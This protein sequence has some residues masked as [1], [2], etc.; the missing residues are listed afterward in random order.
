[1]VKFIINR[2][3]AVLMT[4][5]AFL[6][7]GM[8][9]SSR[10]PTALLPD[11]AIPEITVQLTYP[12]NTAR[13]METNVVRVLRNQLLQ[14]PNLKDI[15]SETRDGWAT[16]RLTFDYGTNTDFAFIEANEKIDAALNF[17]PRDLERPKVIK[18]SASD[19]P[20]LNMA[21][22][23]SD[24]YSDERFLELSDFTE[25]VLKKR[26]EQLPDV[27]L[28]DMSGLA[29]PE[30]VVIPNLKK[31]QSLGITNED[32]ATA[33]QQNNFVLGNLLIQN[34]IYQYNF[35]FANP[36]QTTE[37]IDNIFVT[38]NNRLF[39]LKELAQV[40]L[41]PET[42]R[43]LAY[44]NGK[45]AIVLAV[46]K[47]S[48]A[49]VYHLKESLSNLALSFKN[50]YKNIVFHILQDQSQLLK[51]SIDNLKQSLLLGSFLAIIIM[52]F[53]LK[54]LQSPLLIAFSIPVSLVMSLLFMYLFGLSI[55]IIS[56]S[57][58]ILG[59]G[60]MIDNSIIVI[61]NINQKLESGYN[62]IDACGEGTEE[63]ITPLLSSVL[64]TVSVFFPLVFLSGISGALFY[65]QALAVAIGLFASLIV[66]ILL[67]PVLFKLIKNKMFF[68]IKW[69]RPQN[70]N[71]AIEDWY[72]SGYRLF[73]KKKGLLFLIVG[74]FLAIGIILFLKMP[75]GKLPEFKQ[76]ESMLTLDWNENINVRENQKRVDDLLKNIGQ[77]EVYLSQTGEQQYLLN[78]E[79]S[80]SFSEAEVYV[81]TDTPE[82]LQILLAHLTNQL[83]KYPQAVF[84]FNPP[85]NILEYIFGNDKNQLT[86]KVFSKTNREVPPENSL[87]EIESVL[88]FPVQD[89]IPVEKTAYIEVIHENV[90]LYDIDYN[91]LMGELK[92]AFNQ[93]MVDNLKTA[94][95][96][97][98]IKIYY[99]QDEV[100]QIL[101]K[102]FV[103][104]KAD[105]L[106]PMRSLVR[107]YNA[108]KYKSIF[109]DRNGEYLGINLIADKNENAIIQSTADKIRATSD[110]NVRF[111]G[112]YFDLKA[113]TSELSTVILVSL[114]LL[115]FIMAAQ[116]ESLWQPLIILLEIPI[117][118]GGALLLLWLF[119][120]T[121]NI[122]AA[123]GIVVMSGVVIN[124][125]ILK[126][127]TINIFLK[128]GFPMDVS[129]KKA[130]KL[131]FKPIL[132]TSLTTILALGPFLFISGLG[133][134]LQKP[135]ALTV[136]GGMTIGTFVSLYFVPL[137]F[138]WFYKIFHKDSSSE[139]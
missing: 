124:D 49:Q 108:Q 72:E 113:L 139:K 24:N 17:L 128:D 41:R 40:V 38:V 25:T 60:M 45:R 110:F 18:A 7:L 3:I 83:K 88:G 123:I 10:L 32:I 31:I 63:L 16:I 56:L 112:N 131:R 1:M 74:C 23:L 69:L 70:K 93:N 75:Y 105:Q 54:D 114:F 79:N 134:E 82:N 86:A 64:T 13:E 66:S 87:P 15:E 95:K 103:K 35:K 136:I 36:L 22:T 89:L 28:A 52:F 67:I 20:I 65:D 39:R 6:L 55:N 120:G 133:A 125:S 58:L 5:L 68:Q 109:A 61:D 44:Y 132:M 53:F 21:V 118:L 34:G 51:L 37:D 84:Q 9:T 135:L 91:Q 85:K 73:F 137:M 42:E 106:I 76:T 81:K 107:I 14:I 4:T 48:D 90:L 19:I 98:P 96:F 27:A 129:I 11:I 111:S 121:I 92:S 62:L 122:M 138:S 97:I 77:V 100:E 29:R 26:I 101:N 126:I 57:G 33:I 115:Y 117:D 119:G 71:L 46:I 8:A 47:Q 2:P 30:I 12:N 102:L 94:Q 59:V 43:G 116:F 130:G 99:G 78:K 127:H 50:D 104:N 80:K